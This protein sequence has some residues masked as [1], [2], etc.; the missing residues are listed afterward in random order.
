MLTRAEYTSAQS[1][2]VAMIRQAGIYITDE[3]AQ[4]VEVADFGL[5]RLH[6]EGAQILTLVSTDR[7]AAKHVALFP[8]Q[9]LPE[10]WH[11][12]VGEDP[13]KEETIRVVS[14]SARVYIPGE[15]NMREG[16]IPAG[17]E[18]VYTMR[19][20]LIFKPGDQMTLEPGTKHWFQAG[21]QGAVMYSFSSVARD[22]LD[23]FTDPEIK[24]VTQI[25]ESQ[26]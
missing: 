7:I 23:G 1:R 18:S 15:N 6:E 22:V 17:K 26:T 5:G 24:R 3:E 12:R 9:T 20:E 14:G 13:G 11:P 8:N 16:F 4:K 25:Q 19:H 2:A 10:H 21:E